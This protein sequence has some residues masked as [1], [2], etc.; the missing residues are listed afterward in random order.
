[1]K[2]KRTASTVFSPI[3]DVLSQ[4]RKNLR[5]RLETKHSSVATYADTQNTSHI[6]DV[7]PCVDGQITRCISV[8]PSSYNPWLA[9]LCPTA[10][11]GSILIGRPHGSAMQASLLERQKY[12]SLS[13]FTT[14]NG[15]NRYGG[16]TSRKRL[17]AVNIKPDPIYARF[18]NVFRFRRRATVSH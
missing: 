17:L 7:R 11:C 14:C 3:P 13:L 9:M 16:V 18:P 12:S 2:V 1:M 15:W 6:S 8:T 10:S 5:I 4:R